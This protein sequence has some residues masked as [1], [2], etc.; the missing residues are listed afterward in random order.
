MLDNK[1]NIEV[2]SPDMRKVEKLD[3]DN[4]TWVEIK[5]EELNY[6]DIFQMFERAE[7]IGSVPVVDKNGCY[8]FIARSEVNYTSQG[9]EI[10]TIP[11]KL[12]DDYL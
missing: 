8:R 5:F 7:S 6:G 9:P 2:Y 12:G 1:S 3:V 4:K 10:E 11:L